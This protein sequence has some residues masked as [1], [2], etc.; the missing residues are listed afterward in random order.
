L[1]PNDVASVIAYNGSASVLV[2]SAPLD[3][4]ARDRM[5][6]ALDGLEAQGST[7]ISCAIDT[8]MDEIRGH[9]ASVSRI[10]LLSDGEATDG[11]LDEMGFRRLGEN[12]R[13]AGVAI[14]TIGVDVDYNE[15]IMSAL[16]E[17]SNGHH[18]FVADASGLASVFDREF[19]SLTRTVADSVT[20]EMDL[21][22]GVER[23]E[24]LDRAYEQDGSK[25]RIPLGALAA[26]EQK[27]VLV[28]VRIAGRDSGRDDV[29]AVALRFRGLDAGSERRIDGMLS[30]LF[31]RQRDQLSALDPFVAERLT[32]S[33]TAATLT[34]ANRLFA[35]GDTAA[36]ERA[37]STRLG[38]L[39]DRQKT[40]VV[41]A[42]KARAAELSTAFEKQETVLQ[43]AAKGFAHVPAGAAP[44]AT[45]EGRSQVRSNQAAAFDVSR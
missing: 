9:A 42:P 1:S 3:G 12:A 36:A 19:E 21:M 25:L 13:R 22:P 29:A 40:A 17:E 45:R 31:T 24:V 27:S 30:A 6:R 16:A 38:T 18:Y 20:L 37:I 5:V 11:I 39:A 2:P 8:A 41:A 14:T 4:F 23:I 43:Q 33:E 15:R 32:R 44:N 35:S 7:C 28:R 34:E 10:V 26:G